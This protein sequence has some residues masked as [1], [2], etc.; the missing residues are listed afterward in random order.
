[1]RHL[2][3]AAVLLTALVGAAPPAHAIGCVSGAMM[4]GV[5]GHYA[6]RHGLLGAAAGC[7]LGHRQAVANKRAAQAARQ[8]QQQARAQGVDVRQYNAPAPR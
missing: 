2:V 1:M 4:G 3:A 5:A 7:A 8:Q 6:G